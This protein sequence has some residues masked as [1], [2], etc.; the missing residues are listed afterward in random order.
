MFGAGDA[1]TVEAATMQDTRTAV[2]EVLI[3]GGRPIREPVAW[4]GPFVMNTEDEIEQAFADFRAGKLGSIPA[5][6]HAPTNEI[7][8]QIDSGLD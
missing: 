5:S 4:A 3:L 1:V 7:A 6:A 8:E 2:L